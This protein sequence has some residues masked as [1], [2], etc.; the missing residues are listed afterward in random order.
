FDW[1]G[2]VAQV[3]GAIG[4]FKAC[5]KR[6]GAELWMTAQTHRSKTPEHPT[7]ITAPC[8]AYNTL[9]DVAVFLEPHGDRATVRILKDHD[10]NNVSSSHVTLASD[11]LR[12]VTDDEDEQ[13]R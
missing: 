5:A 10:A 2:P 12:L 1:E 8:D 7:S 4:A 11:T 9:I 13:Q 3:A 6:L